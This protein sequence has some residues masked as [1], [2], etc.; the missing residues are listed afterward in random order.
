MIAI[1][2]IFYDNIATS[3]INKLFSEIISVP[4]V[5]YK[6]SEIYMVVAST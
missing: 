5:T 1:L 2:Y 4:C 3:F 6:P